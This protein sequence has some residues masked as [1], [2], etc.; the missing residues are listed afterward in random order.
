MN[1]EIKAFS[2]S[3]NKKTS[4]NAFRRK[5]QIKFRVECSNYY[6]LTVSFLG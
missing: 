5:K 4:K 2:N 3:N 6:E 1:A